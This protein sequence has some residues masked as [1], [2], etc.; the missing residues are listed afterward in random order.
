M[1]TTKKEFKE[2]VQKHIQDAINEEMTLQDVVNN[3]YT[4]KYKSKY[5]RKF[6]KYDAFKEW[7][8]GLPSSLN[9]EYTN[10]GINNTLKSWYEACGEQYDESKL[11]Q[12]E[13]DFYFHLVTREF[14]NL[15]NKNGIQF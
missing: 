15:C 13:S 7:M 8:T 12:D 10:E 9:I 5:E 1:R 11:S 6:P 14:R 2:Q 4:E 3:F